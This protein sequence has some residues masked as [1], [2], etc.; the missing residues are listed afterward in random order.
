MLKIQQTEN[1][2]KKYFEVLKECA[3]FGN[4]RIEELPVLLDC[5]GVRVI[6]PGKNEFIFSDKQSKFKS[7]NSYIFLVNSY[8]IVEVG[9]E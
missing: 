4:I 7:S 2:M 1:T 9:I 6:S 8:V 5:L 3:L